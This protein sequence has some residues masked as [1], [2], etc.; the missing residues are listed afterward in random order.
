[1]MNQTVI[2]LPADVAANQKQ[3]QELFY[4]VRN[5]DWDNCKGFAYLH[6][7]VRDLDELILSTPGMYSEEVKD[8]KT[9][10]TTMIRDVYECSVD[11]AA[12]IL[13]NAY[14]PTQEEYDYIFK[15]EFGKDESRPDYVYE[16]GVYDSIPAEQSGWFNFCLNKWN[17]FHKEHELID[18]ADRGHSRLLKEYR[19]QIEAEWAAMSVEEQ[20]GW[21]RV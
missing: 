11:R 9:R 10:L 13:N 14:I 6:I 21:C 5:N 8:A 12:T 20:N 1:M 3:F 17:A 2:N 16:E 19:Q 18:E 4:N 7:A 15:R